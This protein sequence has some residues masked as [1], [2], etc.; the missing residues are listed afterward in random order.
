MKQLKRPWLYNDNYKDFRDEFP[1]ENEIHP[2]SN[3]KYTDS[4]IN[5][6]LKR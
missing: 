2:Y 5:I 6:R 4:F 1:T 3:C